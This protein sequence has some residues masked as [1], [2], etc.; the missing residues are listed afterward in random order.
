MHLGNCSTQLSE[1]LSNQQKGKFQSYQYLGVAK[2][3]THSWPKDPPE[4]VW[5]KQREAERAVS[6]PSDWDGVR[7]PSNS[8][9][10]SALQGP[11]V[12]GTTVQILTISLAQIEPKRSIM[13]AQNSSLVA[14]AQ[15]TSTPLNLSFPSSNSRLDSLPASNSFSSSPKLN[16]RFLFRFIANSIAAIASDHW[17]ILTW[18]DGTWQAMK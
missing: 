15:F 2:T 5:E 6:M 9:A 17:L 7:R 18:R 11:Q 12:T 4:C 16:L 1:V 8:F 10:I 3:Q 14:Q 13:I